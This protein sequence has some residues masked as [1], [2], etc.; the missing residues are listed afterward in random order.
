MTY[1]IK[2]FPNQSLE[3]FFYSTKKK[4]KEKIKIEYYFFNKFLLA[5]S[6]F[7]VLY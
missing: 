6:H 7:T 2:W 5:Y 3:E 4:K 1:L